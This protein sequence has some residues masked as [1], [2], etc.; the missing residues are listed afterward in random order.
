MRSFCNPSVVVECRGCRLVTKTIDQPVKQPKLKRDF[1]CK[2]CKSDPQIRL[3]RHYVKKFGLE[4]SEIKRLLST[5]HTCECCGVILD[6]KNPFQ[7]DHCHETGA[8]RGIICW[9]CNSAIGKLGDTYEGV[10][11]AVNYLKK[12][13][14]QSD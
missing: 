6:D 9:N 11:R 7:V 3:I 13:K 4:V 14:S 1:Y 12:Y 2:S 5:V 8:I 10:L